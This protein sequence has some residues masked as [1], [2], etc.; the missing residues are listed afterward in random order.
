MTI[1]ITLITTVWA[2]TAVCAL[3]MKDK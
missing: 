2:L 3:I 1:F